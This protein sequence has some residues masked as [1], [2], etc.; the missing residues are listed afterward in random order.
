MSEGI[1]KVLPCFI[2]D[3]EEILFSP[4]VRVAMPSA[5]VETLVINDFFNTLSEPC[6]GFSG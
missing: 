6:P 3:L 5:K 2:L 1:E 4:E